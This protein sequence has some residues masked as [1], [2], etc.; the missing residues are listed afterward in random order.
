MTDVLWIRPQNM[1]CSIHLS[2]LYSDD[3]KKANA[4]ARGHLLFYVYHIPEDRCIIDM[5][6]NVALRKAW[7]ARVRKYIKFSLRVCRILLAT[8]SLQ[9]S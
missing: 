7:K 2:N 8:L 9:R 6:L 5:H 3:V 1:A 4:P